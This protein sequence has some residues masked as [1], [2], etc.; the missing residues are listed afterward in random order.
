MKAWPCPLYPLE[1][2]PHPLCQRLGGPHSSL[3]WYRKSHPHWDSIPRFQPTVSSYTYH[4]VS[5]HKT[6]KNKI[7][8]AN[9]THKIQQPTSDIC[10]TY[11][12]KSWGWPNPSQKS[13][14]MNAS[15]NFHMQLHKCTVIVGKP[16][17]I[18]KPSLQTEVMHDIQV[19]HARIYKYLHS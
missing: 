12:M 14:R 17:I 1:R 15:E 7:Y 18:R 6:L 10:S 4:A 5:A 16:P 8:W 11:C 19:C 13:Q 9:L 2:T 3:D